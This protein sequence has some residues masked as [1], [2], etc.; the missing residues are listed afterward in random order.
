MRSNVWQAA[1]GK[2]ATLVNTYVGGDLLEPVEGNGLFQ[3][4]S[5]IL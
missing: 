1:P 5:T 4:Q 3:Y 2:Q